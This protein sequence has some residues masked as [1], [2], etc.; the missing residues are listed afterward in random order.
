[1]QVRLWA[2]HGTEDQLISRLVGLGL[3]VDIHPARRPASDH[4]IEV[5][6]HGE[7]KSS[8]VFKEVADLDVIKG[9][10]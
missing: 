1:M 7:G 6:V 4:P 5:I 9:G 3:N 8:T 2:A 10:D